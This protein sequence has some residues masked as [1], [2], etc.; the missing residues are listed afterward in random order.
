MRAV[1][2]A[3]STPLRLAGDAAN[4]AAFAFFVWATFRLKTMTLAHFALAGAIPEP[5]MATVAAVA[6][7]PHS[8][9][10]YGQWAVAW[11]LAVATAGAAWMALLGGRW[12]YLFAVRLLTV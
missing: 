7:D 10:H 1:L 6:A 2:S 8:A 3:L 4:L 12:T 9:L 5:T 11:V